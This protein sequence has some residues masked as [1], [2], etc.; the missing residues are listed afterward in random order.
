MGE[1]GEVSVG[2]I[3]FLSSDKRFDA[4]LFEERDHLGTAGKLLE[5]IAVAPGGVD[6]EVRIE[7][8]RITLE[9]HLVVAATRSAVD[10]NLTT[11][12]LHRGK[13]LLDGNRAG[14]T[15]GVP[16]AAVVHSLALDRLKADIGHFLRNVDNRRIDA[17]GSHTLGDVVDILLVSLADVGGERLNLHARVEKNAA[18]RLGVETA[19]N[20]YANGLT[21]EIF[22]FHIID[23][24]Q[25]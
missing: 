22:K 24:F 25:N 13:K 4:A 23:S 21:F 9:A 20:A 14:D 3:L 8:I 15:R 19:R 6:A 7:N 10:E 1:T 16:V 5:K 11:G 18:N 2:R 17:R 12:L